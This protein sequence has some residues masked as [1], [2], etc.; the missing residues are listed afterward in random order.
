MARPVRPDTEAGD[1]RPNAPISE[2]SREDV[3]RWYLDQLLEGMSGKAV[4]VTHGWTR[5]PELDA[6]LLDQVFL[7][8][9]EGTLYAR[10]YDEGERRDSGNGTAV[11]R[12][13]AALAAHEWRGAT[14][15]EARAIAEQMRY[16]WT[17]D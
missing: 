2:L 3:K 14:D 4:T 5:D 1:R 10:P 8:G 9:K 11:V 16:S 7:Y 15:E 6:V 17:I 12:M 13:E